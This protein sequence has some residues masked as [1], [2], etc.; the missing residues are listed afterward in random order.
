M[1]QASIN[2]GHFPS[3]FKTTTTIIMRKPQKPNYTKPNAY[4]PIALESTIGKVLESVMAEYISYLCETHK[5]LPKHHFRGRPG[6]TTEDAMLI[7]SE[8]IH[9]AWKEGNVYS[10]VLM[11]VA[12]AFNNVHHKR[13]IHNMRKRK[14]PNEI[15]ELGT[16]P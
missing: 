15:T 16:L 12:G 8:S 9:Q 14:I 3:C 13:L 11:D 10:A 4:R 6:R 2:L 7:L 1:A 5:L